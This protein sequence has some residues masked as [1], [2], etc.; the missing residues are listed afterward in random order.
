[1]LELYLVICTDKF[2]VFEKGGGSVQSFDG[3]PYFEY[4]PSKISTATKNLLDSLLENNNLDSRDDLRFFVVESWDLVRNEI[5][6]GRLGEN[7]V[8]SYSLAEAIERAFGDF[9]QDAR[10]Y[11]EFGLNYDGHS[12]QLEQGR[13]RSGEFNLLAMTIEPQTLLRYIA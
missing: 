2:Y 13:T 11:M 4:E 12:Y 1:M 5:V 9:S 6:L 10:K 8:H 3:N 7:V